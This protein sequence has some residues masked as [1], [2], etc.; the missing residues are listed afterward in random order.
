MDGFGRGVARHRRVEISGGRHVALA[1]LVVGDVS[2]RL[3]GA[4]DFDDAVQLVIAVDR[5]GAV[6]MND[7][8]AAPLVIVFITCAAEPL[9]RLGDQLPLRVVG[10]HSEASC[11]GRSVCSAS[12]PSGW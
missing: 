6:G 3:M 12:D 7:V 8:V 11:G 9:D 1:I 5:L 2:G 10:P 4:A